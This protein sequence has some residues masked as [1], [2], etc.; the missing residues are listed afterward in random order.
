[1]LPPHSTHTPIVCKLFIF[2]KGDGKK[3]TWF[4]FSMNLILLHLVKNK[5]LRHG[6]KPQ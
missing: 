6:R 2:R 3:Y 1:M 4:L 5:T